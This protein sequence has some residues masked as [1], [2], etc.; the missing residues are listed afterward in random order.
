MLRRF[1][2]AERIGGVVD[3]PLA[4]QE[5][6]HVAGALVRQF[7]DGVDDAL[8]LVPI[9]PIR[10]VVDQRSISQL[11]RERA[12]GDLDHRRRLAVRL[13]KCSAKRAVSIVA[14]VTITF[15]SGRCGRSCFR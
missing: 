9:G 4:R 2:P 12:S 3:L 1:E 14:V 15:R 7:L 6:E 11:D 8:H 13:A 10:L 5:H